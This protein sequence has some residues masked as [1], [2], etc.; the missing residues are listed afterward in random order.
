MKK[1]VTA[2][3]CAVMC[4][5][6]FT[7][8]S[9]TELGYLQM[10]RDMMVMMESC[11][12]KGQT[13]FDMDFDALRSFAAAIENETGSMGLAE[14][15]E[16]LTG[17]HS[18][19]LDYTMDMD[20]NALNYRLD[21]AM[22]YQDKKYDLGEMYFGFTHGLIVSSDTLL[23]IYHLAKDM[24]GGADGSYLFNSEFEQALAASL[25]KQYISLY[26]PNE[27]A[28]ELP[29]G[30]FGDL[31]DSVFQFYKEMLEGFES[32]EA[33][34][35]EI[36]GGYLIET[37][38]KAVSQLVGKLL[39]FFAENPEQ[40]LLAAENY[41]TEVAKQTG[42]ADAADEMHALFVELSDETAELSES[43][44]ETSAMWKELMQESAARLILDNFH[45][46]YSIT[47]NGSKYVSENTYG[48]TY[49]GKKAFS[50]TSKETLAK[51]SASIAF[52]KAS[53]T[54]D[55]VSAKL[56]D[57]TAQFNPATGVALTWG[58][59]STATQSMLEIRRQ[60]PVPFRINGGSSLEDFAVR[61][62]RA[63]APLRAVCDAL[64]ETVTWNKAE[65]KAYI[66]KDGKNI[67]MDGILEGGKSFVG[68]R[69]FEKLGYTVSYR[70]VDGL[71]EAVI[72]K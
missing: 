19:L 13:Q 34:V 57:L 43:L 36:S 14:G 46:R 25:G 24:T 22:T 44:R 64:G 69:E 54:L 32:D 5:T 60:E 4:L 2:L 7:G 55:D 38:G 48:I 10:C 63:Y 8:C 16:D 40:F 20:I 47:Q 23:G 33:L 67:A 62:G 31:Y 52:P 29:G 30:G 71:K 51:A 28:Q 49:N 70:N 56:D 58:F 1:I 39:D 37:D 65:R 11:Q 27:L 61:N 35:K 59:E 26:S 53:L 41:M 18:V 42:E 17:S 68:I 50:I 6:A 66:A 45:Y 72:T 3:L 12:I 9:K 15:M 21:M